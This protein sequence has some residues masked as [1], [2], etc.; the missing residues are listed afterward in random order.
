VIALL[1]GY[2]GVA[3]LRDGATAVGLGALVV[4]LALVVGAAALARGRRPGA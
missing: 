2:V 1:V 4:A 3:S